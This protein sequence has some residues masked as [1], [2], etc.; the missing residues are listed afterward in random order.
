MHDYV[1]YISSV[2]LAEKTL[3]SDSNKHQL[4]IDKFGQR[5]RVKGILIPCLHKC[6]TVVRHHQQLL[7]K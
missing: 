7:N 4:L 5:F 1:E 6:M 2:V 3:M